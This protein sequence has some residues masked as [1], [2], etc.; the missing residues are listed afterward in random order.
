MGER[1]VAAFDV[2]GTLT[3][4]DTLGPFLAYAC[5]LRAVAVAAARLAPELARGALRRD[6]RDRAKERLIEALLRDRDAA[7]LGE[8]GRRYAAG[9][10]RDGRM[11]D[12]TLRRLAWH[13]AE[14]HEVVLV[15]AS[16]AVYLE[17]LGEALG[18]TAVVATRLEIDG[19]GRLTGRFDGPNVRGAEK[20]RRLREW[21]GAGA[22][23]LWAY[24]NSIDDEPMLARAE[25]PHRIGR[26]PL[27]PV[28]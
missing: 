9:L 1:I 26:R 6:E 17:P 10:H 5:G 19:S 14:G 23:E 7:E 8:R 21:L 22:F 15:S 20:V 2:D 3:R 16:P 24:G 12:D 13:R 25:F 27:P 18:A 11:R 4:H 28:A